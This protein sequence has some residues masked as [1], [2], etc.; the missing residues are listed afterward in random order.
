MKLRYFVVVCF[1][2]GVLGILY[3]AFLRGYG[4]PVMYSFM[5]CVAMFGIK[6]NIDG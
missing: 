2:I 4:E 5:V 1:M 6:E 3:A